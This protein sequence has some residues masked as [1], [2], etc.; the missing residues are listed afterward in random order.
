MEHPHCRAVFGRKFSKS[1]Q[2]RVQKLRVSGNK[3][4]LM[5]FFLF[6]NHGTHVVPHVYHGIP[7]CD[8]NV[9]QMQAFMAIITCACATVIALDCSCTVRACHVS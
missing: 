5:L 7:R 1:R 4:V 6:S 3:R 9:F 8:F 2:N